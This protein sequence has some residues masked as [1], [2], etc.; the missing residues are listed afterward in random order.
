MVYFSTYF[1]RHYLPRALALYHSLAK[2]CEFFHLFAFCLD[3]DAHEAFEKLH[4]PQTTA[5]ALSQVE[6]AN[7]EL[8]R[9]KAVRSRTEYYYTCGPSFLLYLLNHRPDIDLITHLDADLFFFADPKPI[10][11]ELKGHSVGIIE[12]RFSAWQERLKKFGIFNVGWVSFRRDDNG[13][14]CLR[15]WRE[16]CIEWCYD[17]VEGGRFADQKYLDKFP[18]QFKSVRVIQHSGANVAPWN[19]ASYQIVERNG[20]VYVDS[21]PLIFFHF[22]GFRMIA[23]WLFDTNLG[24]YQTSPSS[25]VRRKI[26]GP[27]IHALR[28]VGTY[29]GPAGSVRNSSRNSSRGFGVFVR[30]MRMSAQV[31]FGILRRAYIVVFSGNV[32]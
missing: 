1:D 20:A 2:H 24:W 29:I 10:F 28:R 11:D 7:P 32:L 6:D 31:S 30:S 3:Q 21:Q 26:F 14:E 17:R 15:W 4:L 25:T 22:Q 9:V 12:H 27:Y 5:I 16:R 18:L 19:V 23:P 13:L 8:L